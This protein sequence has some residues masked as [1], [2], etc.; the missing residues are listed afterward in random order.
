MIKRKP[1]RVRWCRGR[2]NDAV[3]HVLAAVAADVCKG[4]A[5][6]LGGKAVWCDDEP[7]SVVIHVRK[8]AEPEYV[9]QAID[10][11]NI[12]AW[13]SESGAVH[14][15][16]HPWHSI[17]DTDQIVLTVTKVL[18]VLYG[19]HA[20]NNESHQQIVKDKLSA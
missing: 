9:A 6:T 5:E 11:E 15:G 20:T 2:L 18:H 16:T 10:A 19:L 4:L 3:R 13:C 1:R 8:E 14:V 17:K 12:E 7:A